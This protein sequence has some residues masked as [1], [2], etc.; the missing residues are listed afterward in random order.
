MNNIILKLKTVYYMFG[1]PS[2]L[3]LVL[4]TQKVDCVK[5]STNTN[6]KNAAQFANPTI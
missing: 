6:G 2:P 5:K 4:F 1:V 3:A